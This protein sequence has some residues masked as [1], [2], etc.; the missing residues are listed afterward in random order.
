M[1]KLGHKESWVPKNWCFSNVEK[2][3]ESPLNCK[4]IQP[5][6]PKGNLSWIFIGRTDAEAET[7]ILWPLDAKKWLIGKGPDAGEDAE[8]RRRRG[9]QRVR[10]LDGITDLMDMN[11][12]K[13]RELVMD[14]E[15]WRAAVHGVAK[16]WAQLSDWP[17]LNLQ[18]HVYNCTSPSLHRC[19]FGTSSLHACSSLPHLLIMT[20]W[21]NPSET[22]LF[23]PTLLHLVP[24]THP[25]KPH[26]PSDSPSQL[27][28]SGSTH[29][30]KPENGVSS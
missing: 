17:E 26:P 1:W 12:S 21:L 7:P 25:P 10:W 6:H 19:I 2:T 16:S 28:A 18:K 13:L 20:L 9:W 15:A 29:L 27:M 22:E 3:L 5:V 14:R 11:L 8:G 4:K 24:H 30:I 23:T